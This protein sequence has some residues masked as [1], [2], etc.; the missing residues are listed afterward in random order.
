MEIAIMKLEL[1]K[2]T[3]QDC[4]DIYRWRTDPINSQ[5][6]FTGGS[7]TYNDHMIWFD[8]YLEDTESLML[9]AGFDGKSC[10]VLRFDGDMEQKDSI[11]IHGAGLPWLRTRTTMLVIG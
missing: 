2:A 4:K 1:R 10:C 8:G 9:I 11:D 5:G 6:S 7:F 3:I